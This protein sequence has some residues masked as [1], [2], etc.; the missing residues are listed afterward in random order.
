[1]MLF[2]LN[3][4]YNVRVR[5]RRLRVGNMIASSSSGR[6]LVKTAISMG[7]TPNQKII[8]SVSNHCS[9]RIRTSS[10]FLIISCIKVGAIR[11]GIPGGNILG[12]VLH[13]RSL[14]LSRM[15]I[16]KC[17]GFSGSSFAKS[18]GALQTSVLGGI[19]M[20]SIRRGLRN[21][22]AKIGVASTSNRPKT[23]RD[24]HVH[25]V[26]SF[27]TSGRPLFIVSNMPI[28]SNDVKTNANTSTTCVGGTGAGIVDALG[29]TSV[30]GVAIVGS[31]TTTSLCNSHTTGKIVLVAAG[32]KTMKHAGIALD[33]DKNFSG[34][35]IGFHPALGK[36]RHHRVVCRN[37]C[38]STMSRKLRSPKRCTGIG[39]SSCTKVPRLKCAS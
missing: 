37:L 15:I 9:L 16:A 38:G 26:N 3:Y 2:M 29:P 1:M 30:R 11:I 8:A 39:V 24:V 21:V 7:K 19:P 20:L 36:S 17:K 28:A 33:T 27:G 5:T 34:T 22:A 31:T 4:L 32:G 6:P 14:D 12:I 18:T 13:P 10:G 35:T 23:G 25:N